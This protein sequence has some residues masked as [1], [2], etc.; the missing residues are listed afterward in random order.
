MAIP[1]RRL[2][3]LLSFV[4][5]LASAPTLRADEAAPWAPDRT[6]GGHL[7]TDFGVLSLAEWWYL[8]GDLHLA[9]LRGERRELSFY[10]AGSHQE[11]PLLQAGGMPASYLNH[12]RGLYLKDAAPRFD[13]QF[14]YVPRDTIGNYIA[15][16]TPYVG[17]TYPDQSVALSGSAREGYQMR[18]DTADAKLNL[19]Y[20]PVAEK[21]VVQAAAPLRF[22]TT[23][24]APGVV[25]GT[26]ELDGQIY[27]AQG[28][29]YFDHMVPLG[30]DRPWGQTMHGWS[31]SEVTTP[32][33]QAVLYATRGL[34]SGYGGYDF[35]QMTLIDRRTGRV[36]ARYSGDEV[37]VT[38]T[39]WMEEPAYRRRRPLTTIYSAGDV[40]VTVHAEEMLPFNTADPVR[41]NGFVDFMSHERNRSTIERGS[42][43]ESGSS[44][45][46]YLVTEAGVVVA[47]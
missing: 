11:S 31:W 27:L 23:I 43:L 29:G 35:K 21:A 17:F 42:R 10:L 39:D 8:N 32:R 34:A 9:S 26:V 25:F 7:D 30:A 4:L 12:F 36:A 24:Y 19:Y 37:A 46:E 47:P 38:E 45:F 5:L 13:F 33:Y 1:M 40:S 22:D 3:Y 41:R 28:Q 44:F 6:E 18:Y 15:I 2:T 16:G 20:I 14:T